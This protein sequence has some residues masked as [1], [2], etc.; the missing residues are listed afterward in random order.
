[1]DEK[2]LDGI[3]CLGNQPFV[4]YAVVSGSNGFQFQLQEKLTQILLHIF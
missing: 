1:M 3:Q 4:K 2:F